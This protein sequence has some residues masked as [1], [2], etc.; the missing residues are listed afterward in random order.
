MTLHGRH[1]DLPISDSPDKRPSLGNPS[2]SGCLC[3]KA[4]PTMIGIGYKQVLWKHAFSKGTRI[5][6]GLL[7]G[8]WERDQFSLPFRTNM[9]LSVIKVIVLL[10][11][12]HGMRPCEMKQPRQGQRE[13]WT[14]PLQTCL[15]TQASSSMPHVPVLS[16]WVE[17][18]C[19]FYSSCV[20]FVSSDHVL[21]EWNTPRIATTSQWLIVFLYA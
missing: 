2:L 20:V 18:L 3:S 6:D 4:S 1:W 13:T 5:F 11:T 15:S 21:I 19:F 12:G 17:I 7:H 9:W 10:W 14:T 16:P 8:V